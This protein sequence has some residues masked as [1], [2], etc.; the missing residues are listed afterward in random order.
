MEREPAYEEIYVRFGQFD[1]FVS[2]TFHPG[3]ESFKMYG[4]SIMGIFKYTLEERTALEEKIKNPEYEKTDNY[5]KFEP[6]ITEELST[7]Q[8]DSLDK[9]GFISSDIDFVSYSL[10]P[11]ENKFSASGT[12][13]ISYNIIHSDLSDFNVAKVQLYFLNSRLSNGYGLIKEECDEYFGL[14]LYFGKEIS[15]GNYSH[16]YDPSG[17]I[18]DGVRFY[19]LRYKSLSNE[20]NMEEDEELNNIYSSRLAKKLRILQ[21]ELKKASGEKLST[22]GKTHEGSLKNLVGL[23]L[24]FND[25]VLIA[26]KFPIWWDFERLVHIYVRHVKETQIGERNGNKTIFQ[27]AFEEVKDIITMVI[28]ECYDEILEHFENHPDKNFFRKNSRSQYLQGNYYRIDISP[29]GK[30]LSFH[31][32]NNSE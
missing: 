31:P 3:T 18:N 29:D 12:K 21:D 17:K 10:Q 11:M 9:K 2:L 19:Q 25:E 28:E 1:Q 5:L 20:I 24:E 22:I 23:L 15:N 8:R 4:H 30:L 27:Y 14:L 16:V 32:Y 7:E 26:R 6:S 13:R